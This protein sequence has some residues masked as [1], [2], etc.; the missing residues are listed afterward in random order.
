MFLVSKEKPVTLVSITSPTTVFDCS[1]TLT[2]TPG[3]ME[4]RC[5][6][7]ASYQKGRG[8]FPGT[9]IL[10]FGLEFNL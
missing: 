6:C 2:K 3:V 8:K 4:L 5:K 9:I 10:A 7:P 1:G